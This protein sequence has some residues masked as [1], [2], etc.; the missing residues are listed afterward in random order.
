[1]SIFTGLHIIMLNDV[2]HLNWIL[3]E[4]KKAKEQYAALSYLRFFVS[5]ILAVTFLNVRFC[6]WHVVTE[7]SCFDSS[8]A[9]FAEKVS[10]HL[11]FWWKTVFNSEPSKFTSTDPQS[12]SD[13]SVTGK[14]SFSFFLRKPCTMY[15]QVIWPDQFGWIPERC[16]HSKKAP[17]AKSKHAPCLINRNAVLSN[18]KI[19][20]QHSWETCTLIT[21]LSLFMISLVTFY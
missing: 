1:M 6:P 10:C 2:H 8:G 21:S 9:G 19:M 18:T 7:F 15:C 4:L 16:R 17:K 11:Y 12:V 14:F 5:F 3:E 13:Q 20:N